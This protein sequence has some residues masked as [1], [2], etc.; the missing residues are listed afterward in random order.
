MRINYKS[1]FNVLSEILDVDEDNKIIKHCE[2][3][4]VKRTKIPTKVFM[5]WFFFSVMRGKAVLMY[6]V[7]WALRQTAKKKGNSGNETIVSR[8]VCLHVKRLLC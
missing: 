8:Y 3:S 4:P 1:K 5:V 6:G 7:Q 2:N